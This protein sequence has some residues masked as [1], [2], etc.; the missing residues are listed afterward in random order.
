MN[1]AKEITNRIV[2]FQDFN[3]RSKVIKGVKFKADE[4]EFNGYSIEGTEPFYDDLAWDTLNDYLEN[5]VK[6]GWE[7]NPNYTTIK[8]ISQKKR[9]NI[10]YVT[11]DV[12]VY[13][14]KDLDM[15][16]SKWEEVKEKVDDHLWH[17]KGRK[18]MRAAF[19]DAFGEGRTW[20]VDEYANHYSIR[21]Q[22]NLEGW[23]E[24]EASIYL[25]LETASLFG[26]VD[27]MNGEVKYRFPITQLDSMTQFFAISGWM[28]TISGKNK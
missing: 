18:L 13:R 22:F 14:K 15:Y 3:I 10:H 7:T 2:K 25:N 16:L 11:A 9:G 21:S 4:G 20:K 28:K 5:N 8:V 27:G 26:T 23:G 19:Y 6:G 17:K 12:T 24:V 1:K